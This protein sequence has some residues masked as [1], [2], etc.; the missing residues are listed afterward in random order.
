MGIAYTFNA[1]KFYTGSVKTQ[2][3]SF[4]LNSTMVPIPNTELPSGTMWRFGGTEWTAEI[5]PAPILPDPNIEIKANLEVID[6]KSIR[7]IRELLLNDPNC[8]EYLKNYEAEAAA[9]RAKLV[10]VS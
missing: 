9:E 2:P 4:P 5:P 8:P 1:F 10:P 3:G 7:S 6:I